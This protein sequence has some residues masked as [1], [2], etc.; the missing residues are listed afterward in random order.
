[1][2]KDYYDILGIEKGASK[3]EIKKAFRKKAHEFHPDKSTGDEAKFKEVNEAY[4][5]L[6][7]DTKR[8]QYDQFGQ[9]FDGAGPGAGGF[10][11]FGGAQGMNFEDLGDIFGEFFGGG[12]GGFGGF[13]GGQRTK[14]GQD[15]QVDMKLTFK[16]A[17]FGTEKEIELTKTNTCERCAGDGSEP[18]TD[19]KTCDHCDGKGFE[20]KVRQTMLG[21]MQSR[22][23]CHVC[24]GRGE[25]PET[26]CGDCRGSGVTT[27]KK[28]LRVSIP[29]GV[30][31]GMRVRVRGEGEAISG[32]TPGDLF[33]LLY[34]PNDE[35]FEREGAHIYTTKKIGF[36]QAALGDEVTIETLDGKV[37]MKIPAGSESGEKLRLK[38]KGVPHGRMGARGDL[39][40]ELH[41]VTPQKLNR[42]QKK[43]IEELDLREE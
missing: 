26:P 25:I 10:G 20:I 43:A 39:F 41:V 22:Q 9:T 18:G 24:N 15:I 36:T 27:G 17:V 4:Q 1:M 35:Q 14:R 40:V 3:D 42:K 21:A 23:T 2:A 30:E 7:D 32:G 38:G 19:L 6:S 12:G 37:K 13:G 8:Q 29:A 33:V 34:V 5:V 16:E 28:K 11:G 31:H